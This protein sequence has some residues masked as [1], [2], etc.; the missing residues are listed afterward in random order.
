MKQFIWDYP[1]F[2]RDDYP[3]G[4]PKGYE[5]RLIRL[6]GKQ[7][8][9]VIHL[10]GGFSEYGLK[11]DININTMPH[12]LGDAHNT[13]IRVASFSLVICDPPYS[14]NDNYI[15]YGNK[16]D[17]F[18]EKWIDEAKRISREYIATRH[19]KLMPP[20]KGYEEVIRIF[21]TLCP[22]RF[23]HVSQIFKQV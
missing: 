4:F 1:D 12:Y 23:I 3:G 19:L 16:L 18:Y 14:K 6:L 7:S 8:E 2:R 17:L 5:K 9:D 11:G 22:N 15:Y 20:I 13:P 10:F 21:I